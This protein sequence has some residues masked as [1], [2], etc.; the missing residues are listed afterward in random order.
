[1]QRLDAGKPLS[2]ELSATPIGGQGSV[3]VVERWFRH[4]AAEQ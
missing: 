2:L 3:L 4:V 1:V